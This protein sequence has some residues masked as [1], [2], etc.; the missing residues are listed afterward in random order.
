VLRLA[1]YVIAFMMTATVAAPACLAQQSAETQL[2]RRFLRTYLGVAPD[3]AYENSKSI[4]YSPVSFSFDHAD[5]DGD[6][7]PEVIV[8]VS[9]G[10]W[11]GTGGCKLL[12]L[13]PETCS[14]SVLDETHPMHLPVHLLP[15][16]TN[17][18]RDISMVWGGGGLYLQTVVFQFDG[19][20]YLERKGDF[21]G[22]LTVGSKYPPDLIYTPKGARKL[23]LR[24][25]DI[26]LFP[27]NAPKAAPKG[28]QD[29]CPVS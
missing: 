15:G 5:L 14:Y 18:W 20:A 8:Y 11:C 22:D 10:G 29:N 19:K 3:P 28:R 24:D 13:E 6:E 21:N 7:K 4:L 9:G 1:L 2:L 25:L 26:R 16:K 17:G 12:I 27:P 23:T